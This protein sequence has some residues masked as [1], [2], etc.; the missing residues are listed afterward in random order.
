[1]VKLL[2]LD[3]DGTLTDG[4]ISYSSGGTEIK[5]FSVKDGA[6]L[7]RLPNI[8]IDVIF[9]TGRESEAVTRR[10]AE[11][12]AIAIQGIT[13]K[14]AKL[15]ETLTIRGITAERTAYIGDDLNDCICRRRWTPRA[16]PVGHP[17][18]SSWT[19]ASLKSD[20]DSIYFL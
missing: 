6:V 15:R 11:L 9:L 8:G 3:V 14:E 1:M 10:A 19:P 12:N 5:A 20:I 16:V 7:K 17:R 4:S 2:I 18:R 13:D